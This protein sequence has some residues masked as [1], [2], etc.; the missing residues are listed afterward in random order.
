[1]EGALVSPCRS[2]AA[3][4]FAVARPVGVALH[5][6]LDRSPWA[7]V[8][9]K[10]AD[11]TFFVH[12]ARQ[13]PDV[14]GDVAKAEDLV[15]GASPSRPAGGTTIAKLLPKGGAMTSLLAFG[16]L[17]VGL[18]ALL[19][20]G[21]AGRFGASKERGEPVGVRRRLREVRPRRRSCSARSRSGSSSPPGGGSTSGPASSTTGTTSVTNGQAVLVT[22]LRL[23]LFLVAA[24]FARALAAFARASMGLAGRANLVRALGQ[25][26]GT[27]LRR[28]GKSLGLEVL[29][30]SAALAPLIL[31]GLVAP[32]W[33]GADRS[34]FF[35]ILAG[36]QLVVFFRIAARA[37]HLGAATAWL[38]RA[39]D[40]A[41][42]A[43]VEAA[44]P[45]F[46]A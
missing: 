15:T 19:A 9:L 31:W 10:S 16:M 34:R 4:A 17:N 28:P 25:A 22:L 3:L 18:A 13:R 39:R 43:P 8:L 24:G 21:F 40:G 42:P 29:C 46:A 6:T 20:G 35:L 7:D 33:D 30:G 5:E 45:G 12:F 2:N 36:Q 32:T 1:M 11:A 38:D 44:P 23:G 37:A 26:I 41:A 14:L 27:I